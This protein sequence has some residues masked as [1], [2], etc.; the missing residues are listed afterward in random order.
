MMMIINKKSNFSHNICSIENENSTKFKDDF[1]QNNF[2]PKIQFKSTSGHLQTMTETRMMDIEKTLSNNLIIANNNAI[3]Q[4]ED[5]M[6]NVDN[7]DP[8]TIQTDEQQQQQEKQHL[9]KHRKFYGW[10]KSHLWIFPF[11]VATLKIIIC[12]VPYI[13][14]VKY[15]TVDPLLPY[16]S[17]AGGLPP[18]SFV[19]SQ[20]MDLIAIFG[21]FD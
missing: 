12:I 13:L 1:S 7:D 8:K 4:N 5:S 20:I 19:L 15:G 11:F 17:D 9:K 16:V 18:G 10:I 14:S 2:F 3:N 6:I 21:E